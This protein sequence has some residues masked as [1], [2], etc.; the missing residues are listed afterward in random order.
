MK[1]YKDFENRRTINRLSMLFE[2]KSK[3]HA[4]IYSFEISITKNYITA[5]NKFEIYSDLRD[6]I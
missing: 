4:S 6:A 2:Q 3:A 1:N 5:G